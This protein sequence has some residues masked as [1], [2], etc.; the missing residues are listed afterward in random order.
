MVSNDE[1]PET[2]DAALSAE[3][4][5]AKGK[6][7]FLS[8]I[9]AVPVRPDAMRDLRQHGVGADAETS[10]ERG[11]GGQEVKGEWS[12]EAIKQGNVDRARAPMPAAG[13]PDLEHIFKYHAPN[14]EQLAQYARLREAARRFAVEIVQNSP[15]GADQTAALR[16]IREAV[17]TAN[18]AI[19]LGGRINL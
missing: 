9:Q 17:M 10:L 6:F 14:G 12:R 2:G 8:G 16:K 5:E 3:G 15:A 1:G 19:A 13:T 4:R 11:A 7:P 18:A